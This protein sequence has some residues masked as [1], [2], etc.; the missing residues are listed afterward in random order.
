MGGL[1]ADDSAWIVD[2]HCHLWAADHQAAAWPD[3][4]PP[5]RRSFDPGDLVAAVDRR[6]ATV[7][8][9]E[10]G[11]SAGELA[12][13]HRNAAAAPIIG[14]SVACADPLDPA[15]PRTLDALRAHPACRGVRLRLEGLPP[16]AL[17]DRRV[18]ASVREIG[19]R[20]LVAEFLVTTAQLP[21]LRTVAADVPGLRGIVDHMAK[22]ALGDTSDRAAWEE[23]MRA[24][25]RDTSLAVK[26][27][28][29]PRASEIGAF[30]E[31]DTAWSADRLRPYVQDL[32]E[33]F[34]PAR[35]A[36][37]SDWPIGT[38]GRPHGSAIERMASALGLIPEAARRQVSA[39]TV[40]ALYA[41]GEVPI[42]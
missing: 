15:L 33:T 14:A 4:P 17:L 36:W 21:A 6:V 12:L 40:N 37:G 3:A 1:T 26:L 5:L 39:G 38:A 2:A 7:V 8:L 19:A 41:I 31:D 24:L 20:G 9:V 22:P 10:A 35:L 11:G 27:S 29:S 16:E 18:G 28:V 34:S 13:L 25:A 32:L 42:R 30:I 23:G